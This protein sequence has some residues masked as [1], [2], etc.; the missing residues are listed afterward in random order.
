MPADPKRLLEERILAAEWARRAGPPAGD[1]WAVE[2]DALPPLSAIAPRAFPTWVLERRLRFWED[3]GHRPEPT[4]RWLA[5]PPVAGVGA[6]DVA[7]WVYGS[8]AVETDDPFLASLAR[9]LGRPCSGPPGDPGAPD[10]LDRFFDRWA[11]PARPGTGRAV[12]PSYSRLESA[13]AAADRWF[14]RRGAGAGWERLS[15]VVGWAGRVKRCI[16]P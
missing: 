4:A 15:E 16:R 2:L 14:G 7:A 5:G 13:S 1:S 3:L 11:G 6:A 10:R 12:P 9:A 8:S